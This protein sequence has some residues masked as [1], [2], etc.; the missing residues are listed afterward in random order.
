MTDRPAF[1]QVNL[2]VGDVEASAAFYRLAGLDIDAGP[3]DWPAGTGGQHANALGDDSAHLDLDNAEFARLWGHPGLRAGA[4]VV[5]VSLPT[6]EA[7]DE[8][9]ARLVAAGHEGR[10][11]PYDAFVGARYAIVGDPD[12]HDVGLMS[13]RDQ[14][15]RFTPGPDGRPAPT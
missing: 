4:P 5:G 6:R 2:V 1:T 13:P 10:L 9:Y 3:G 11:E 7:V 8:T 14:E 15:R 12:G